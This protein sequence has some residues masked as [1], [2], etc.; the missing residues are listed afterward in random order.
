MKTTEL[1][2]KENEG[3]IKVERQRNK[4]VN[5]L[6]AEQKY[7][8]I[9]ALI[10]CATFIAALYRT[11]KGAFIAAGVL[12]FMVGIYKAWQDDFC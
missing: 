11:G 8:I 10:G 7:H 5:P 1:N 4:P 3:K 2:I 6:S 9:L 12:L